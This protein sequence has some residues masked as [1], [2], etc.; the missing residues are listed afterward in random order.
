MDFVIYLLRIAISYL[1]SQVIAFALSYMLHCRAGWIKLTAR[2][3]V[4][5]LIEH[6]R[7]SFVERERERERPACMLQGEDDIWIGKVVAKRK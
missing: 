1:Q 7:L 2:K 6:A 3:R 4:E 5:K